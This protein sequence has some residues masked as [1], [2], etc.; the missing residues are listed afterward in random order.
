MGMWEVR[1]LAFLWARLRRLGLGIYSNCTCRY[2]VKEGRKGH[3]TDEK[4]W[5]DT[6]FDM[7]L[8]YMKRLRT[9]VRWGTTSPWL[10]PLPWE[11]E[12][13]Q[14]PGDSAFSLQRWGLVMV[15]DVLARRGIEDQ[16]GKVTHIPELQRNLVKLKAE[17]VALCLE[18]WQPRT[19]LS[20]RIFCSVGNML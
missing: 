19:V 2:G 6:S 10:H 11:L 17:A 12:R 13:F 20:S 18:R 8:S 4:V 14:G 1:E 5:L 9:G 16:R 7:A 15:D 3:L